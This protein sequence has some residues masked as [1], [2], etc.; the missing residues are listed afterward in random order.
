MKQR[1]R[2]RATGWRNDSTGILAIFADNKKFLMPVIFFIAVLI[3]VVVVYKA[4]RMASESAL[5]G[6]DSSV[7][8]VNEIQEIT[9]EECEDQNIIDLVTRYYNAM[10]EGNKTEVDA[11]YRGL[12]NAQGL[13]AEAI[14]KFIERYD[15]IKVYTKPGPIQNSYIAYV[16][17]MV[18]LYDYEKALPGLET[19]YICTDENGELFIN[20]DSED[21]T[22]INYIKSLSVQADVI[23]LNNKVASEYNEMIN[24]DENLAAQLTNMRKDIQ[25][26]VAEAMVN[27]ATGDASTDISGDASSTD[28][29]QE[30]APVTYTI[31]A[32]ENVKIRKG[33]STDAEEIG[34]A[35][36]GD[37]FKE[38][39][40]LPS[41][42]SKIEYNGGEAYVKSEFFERVDNGTE[43]GEG[44]SAT[45][46]SSSSA[47]DDSAGKIG[48]KKIKADS[49][50][51]RKGQGTDSA[52]LATID[53]GSTVNVIEENSN[54]WSKV[55]YDGQTGYIKSELIEQ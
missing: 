7:G 16:Y 8:E 22:I 33:D 37:E 2:S 42:W 29:S 47:N 55:E 11:I 45:A 12:D 4:N 18:K 5:A 1:K 25:A 38:L 43:A 41:G 10:A 23:D 50:R 52:I 35:E 53:K 6:N 31:K 32:K 27:Q 49:V 14:S 48:T 36:A 17:N 54:G 13:K 9:M 26:V 19:L 44:Q 39:E 20:G 21:E 40:A 3:T 15:S 34:K 24:A 30:A 28:A 46:D 51:L